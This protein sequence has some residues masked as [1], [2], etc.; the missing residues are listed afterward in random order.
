[1]TKQQL[2]SRKQLDMHDALRLAFDAGC[3]YATASHED[4]VQIHEAREPVCACL[5]LRVRM[6]RR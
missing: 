2:K 4:F 5:L 6:R 1:M 3:S